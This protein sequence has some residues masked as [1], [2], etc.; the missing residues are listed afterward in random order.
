MDSVQGVTK[1]RPSLGQ[2]TATPAGWDR[3]QVRD[4]ECGQHGHD[5]EVRVSSGAFR[6]EPQLLRC[7]HCAKEW[8][9]VPN[10]SPSDDNEYV[11]P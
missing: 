4:W 6:G 8:R 3:S 2:E 7:R 10:W 5:F 1:E 9:T 11:E